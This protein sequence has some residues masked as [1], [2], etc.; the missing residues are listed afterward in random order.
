MEYEILVASLTSLA[1]LIALEAILG[2]DNLVFLSILSNKLPEQQRRLAR[3]LGLAG[4]LVFRLIML[5]FATWLV[6]LSQPIFTLY[7]HDVSV[8]DI[9]LL[10]GGLF[11]IWKSVDE[12][13]G[14]VEG[15]D[16][17]GEINNEPAGS[18]RSVVTQIMIFDIIFSIDSVITAVGL[19]D[20]LYIMYIAVTVAIIIMMTIGQKVGDFVHKHPTTTMLALSFLLIIGMSLIAESMHFEIPKGYIYSAMGF[21]ILV[22]GLN[23][24]AIKRRRLKMMLIKSQSNSKLP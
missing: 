11:L 22:E 2:V 18:F 21:A 20:Q 16:L 4:A 15:E 23:L 3:N 13:H 12:I 1:A 6:Q 5:G 9:I 8:R 14:H 24:T 10:A 19:T 17:E 7:N